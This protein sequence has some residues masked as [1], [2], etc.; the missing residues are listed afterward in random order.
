MQEKK[1]ATALLNTHKKQ[2]NQVGLI[3][4]VIRKNGMSLR[5]KMKTNTLL[6]AARQAKIMGFLDEK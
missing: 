6:E 2:S 5:E 4:Q 3:A 1:L